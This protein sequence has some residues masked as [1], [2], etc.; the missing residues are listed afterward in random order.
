M[1]N[2]ASLLGIALLSGD[3]LLHGKA[4]LGLAVATQGIASPLWIAHLSEDWL[5]QS[6]AC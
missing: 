3:G 6:K 4:C 2:F 5:L 1:Q